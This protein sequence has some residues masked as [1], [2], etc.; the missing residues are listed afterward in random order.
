MLTRSLPRTL[1]LSIPAI[2]VLLPIS[3][4]SQL[5]LSK[6]KGDKEEKRQQKEEKQRIKEAKQ[7]DTL[8]EYAQHLYETNT[9]FQEAVDLAYQ[10]CLGEHAEEAYGVN[11]APQLTITV[12]RDSFTLQAAE[13]SATSACGTRTAINNLYGNPR[14]QDYVNRVG[15]QLVPTNSDRLYAFR[16]TLAPT[17]YAITLSTGTIYISTGLISMTD[18]EAQLAYI[19]SHEIAH[20]AKD[21]WKT[22][23]MDTLAVDKY[24]EKEVIKKSIIGATIG[25]AIGGVAGK[26]GT[27]VAEGAVAGT[28]AGALVGALT[29]WRRF[30]LDW[31]DA[32]ENEADDFALQN[33]LKQNY[34]PQ[35]VPKLYE[36][37]NVLGAADQRVGLG[38]IAK[39]SRI[40]YRLAYSQKQLQ[41]PPLKTEYEKR[42]NSGRLIGTSPSY[43]LMMADLKRDNGIVALEF[44]MFSMAKQNLSQAVSLRTDDARGHFYYGVVLKLV[45]RTDAERQQA[46]GEFVEAIKL[47]QQRHAIPEAELERALMLMDAQD[48]KS[49]ADA[50]QALENYI[51]SY[52]QD[53]VERSKYAATI[54]PNIKTLY[55]YL[56]LV[57]EPKWTPPAPPEDY[58]QLIAGGEGVETTRAAAHVKSEPGRKEALN[59]SASALGRH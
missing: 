55:D 17:P 10:D 18:N 52:Q 59:Q 21:H 57:G 38:F 25:A 4:H 3:A 39:P 58:Y 20:V 48:S 29:T 22:K 19:L 40:K 35:E 12:G 43:E 45:G 53:R 42:L 56:R 47:D 2:V 30:G 46:K 41:T 23:I 31:G 13:S 7:Y 37:L 33:T 9:D 15:Q 14:I 24:N 11:N 54:P 1:V 49:Q 26:S 36:A 32:Q 51:V 6:L 8:S 50:A 16:V 44:D 34:D 28:A 5:G 27:A